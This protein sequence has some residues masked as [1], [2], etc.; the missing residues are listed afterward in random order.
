MTDT[1]A[2]HTTNSVFYDRISKAYDLIADSSEH[3]YRQ[4]GIESMKLKPGDNVLEI[5]FGTGNALL[6]IAEKVVP[7]GHVVGIDISQGMLDVAA[8]KI[9]KKQLND[10]IHLQIETARDLPFEENQFDAAFMCFTLE[11]FEDEEIPFVLKEAQRVLKPGGKLGNVSLAKVPGDEHH[12]L[13]EMTYKWFHHHFPH[14]VDCKPIDAVQVMQD[15]G[16]N[17]TVN[18]REEMWEMPV[19]M[20]VAEK[21][22]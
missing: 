18:K 13:M 17:I 16:F 1:P 12:S 9:D 19:S 20:I 7:N 4:V 6:E 8:E 22:A 11:L 5:G 14:I 10:V 21:V 15:A 2:D 3:H